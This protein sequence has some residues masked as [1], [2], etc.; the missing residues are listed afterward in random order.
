MTPTEDTKRALF[1][2]VE[3]FRMLM[4]EHGA[5]GRLL[6]VSPEMIAFSLTSCKSEDALLKAIYMIDGVDRVLVN[7]MRRGYRS[8]Q[9]CLTEFM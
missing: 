3:K 5:S 2:Q 7:G 1:K 8:L 9:I 4:E 6:D